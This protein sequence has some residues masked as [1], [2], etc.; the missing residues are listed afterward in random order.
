LIFLKPILDEFFLSELNPKGLYKVHVQK[1]KSPSKIPF[2]PNKIIDTKTSKLNAAITV[3]KKP[4]ARN[5]LYTL[6]IF[7]YSK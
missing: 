7:F 3:K 2:N 4:I 5:T 6:P 1:N